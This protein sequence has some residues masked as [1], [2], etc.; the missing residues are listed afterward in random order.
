MPSQRLK[1]AKRYAGDLVRLWPE[2]SFLTIASMAFARIFLA[3]RVVRIRMHG[4]S[5]DVR[6]RSPDVYVAWETLGR[7]F[8]ALGKCHPKDTTGVIIDLGGYIGTAAIAFSRM[9][10]CARIITVEPSPENFELLSRNIKGRPNITAI[11]AAITPPGR[12]EPILLTGGDTGPWGFSTSRF[13]TRRPSRLDRTVEALPIDELLGGIGAD[14]ALLVKIDIEGSELDLLEHA[15]AWIGRCP[16]VLVEL[17][18]RHV[19]GCTEAFEKAFADR[20]VFR[21]GDEKF[22]ALDRRFFDGR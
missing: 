3:D 15:D 22:A 4:A 7:E 14:R 9:F 11:N 10:P 1:T 21:L 18:D 13:A 6:T 16:L 20:F 5:L 8:L 12:K 19:A 2:N 17:H